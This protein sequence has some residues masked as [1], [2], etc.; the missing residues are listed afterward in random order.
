[1]LI[2]NNETSAKIKV[3][4]YIRVSTTE[5]KIDG[6]GLEAQKKKLLD[7]VHNNK[8]L[9][10]ITKE[11]WLFCDVHTGSELNR[12]GLNKLL[13]AAKAKKFDSV[14]VWKIDRLSCS[15]Q[16]LL[17]VF[18][19]FEK[20]NVSF[21]SVQENIDFRGAIGKLI[22]QIFGAIAQF[23][24]ELIKGRTN[25]GKIASAEMGNY[26]GNAVPYGYKT[27]PNPNGKG[28]RLAIIEQEQKWVKEIFK[29]YIYEGLGWGAIAKK[30]NELKVAK[31]Q[32][33]KSKRKF[34][35][36]TEKIIR[37]MIQNSIYRGEFVANK[38]DDNGNFL[39]EEQW[40]VVSVPACISELTYQQAQ[41]V[42][43]NRTS[44][45]NTDYLLSGK[46]KD[47]TLSPP[48]SFTGAKR[49]KGGFS[50]RRKQF[51]DKKGTHVPVFEIPGKPVEDYVWSKIVKAMKSPELFIKYYLS[52]EYTEPKRIIKLEEELVHLREQ[53]VNIELEIG[54][55]EQAFEKGIYSE[56]KLGEKTL[57]KNKEIAGIEEK[58]QLIEDKISLM[59]AVDIEVEKLK[60]ASEEVKYKIEKLNQREKKIICNLF[61]DRI[62]LYRT[63]IKAEK[64]RRQKWDVKAD[65]FFRFNP[66]KFI[67]EEGVGR[68]EKSK[69]NNK[70]ESI[71]SQSDSLGV[72]GRT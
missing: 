56:E 59:S 3:A 64:G 55:T 33:S 54:R 51:K 61:I 29:W 24:R 23:E 1:M 38:K 25:M 53:R 31:G 9:N 2:E 22:F 20:H 8:A 41:I 70:K 42:R 13:E 15:L 58:I 50:Y 36:W 34:S 65:I 19:I 52:K 62:E 60:D 18:D 40:T 37:T 66:E 27:V 48:K 72:T 17:K 35:K 11:E 30:L 44:N 68:T 6:Y 4:I 43:T 46:I 16:H 28:K 12:E 5:Q 49:S 26:T 10:L 69:E 71:N 7:Y 67:Q 14:L 57:G 39:H 32:Y 45:A 47:M 21:V 63:A